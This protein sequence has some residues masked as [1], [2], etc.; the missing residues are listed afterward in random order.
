MRSGGLSAPLCAFAQV[1]RASASRMAGA[2]AAVSRVGRSDTRQVSRRHRNGAVRLGLV[3][4][5]VGLGQE[6][7]GGQVGAVQAG[8]QIQAV[9]RARGAGAFAQARSPAGASV[10]PLVRLDALQQAVIARRCGP[11]RHR[12]SHRGLWRD[13]PRVSG[14][15]GPK[16]FRVGPQYDA[17]GHVGISS[18]AQTGR[19]PRR[20]IFI[21]PLPRVAVLWVVRAVGAGVT[22]EHGSR[23]RRAH[24]VDSGAEQ[25]SGRRGVRQARA[26][27]ARAPRCPAGGRQ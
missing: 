27:G 10:R 16:R 26:T 17:G 15:A 25:G 2:S 20:G 8:G 12:E 3:A 21:T 13:A 6:L 19:E 23:L 24:E 18:P 11:P 7:R 9:E 4:L 1:A 22:P 14:E 5:A